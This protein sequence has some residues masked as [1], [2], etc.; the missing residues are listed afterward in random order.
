MKYVHSAL[1][2]TNEIL[3]VPG[4][5]LHKAHKST[6]KEV[7]KNM[8]MTKNHIILYIFFSLK[9]PVHCVLRKEN[10]HE[11]KISSSVIHDLV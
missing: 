8:Y 5:L 11:I 9:A 2:Y 6:I 1:F 10:H 3:Q 4:A 7:Q